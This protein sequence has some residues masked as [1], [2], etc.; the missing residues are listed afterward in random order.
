MGSNGCSVAPNSNHKD[1]SKASR[2]KTIFMSYSVCLSYFLF[3]PSHPVP[4][5]KASCA[6]EHSPDFFLKAPLRGEQRQLC[7]GCEPRKHAERAPGLSHGEAEGG[8][9][10]G[11]SQFAHGSPL[12]RVASAVALT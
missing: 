11:G 8:G 10:G 3:S 12:I 2:V 4:K 1:L 7:P 6:L 5:G 9:G